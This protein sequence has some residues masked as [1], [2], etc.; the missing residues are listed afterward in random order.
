MSNLVKNH[1]LCLNLIFHI[2]VTDLVI[3]LLLISASCCCM[4]CEATSDTL[5][6][7]V[8]CFSGER[9]GLLFWL[10]DWNQPSCNV[11]R[12]LELKEQLRGYLFLSLCIYLSFYLLS[13]S[14]APFLLT[15]QLNL[16]KVKFHVSFAKGSSNSDHFCAPNVLWPSA[17]F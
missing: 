4:Y 7:W 15:I 10:L 5:S 1:L 14:M 17:G 11:G 2:R 13:I 16:K 6:F 9:P 8:P 12:I 3:P